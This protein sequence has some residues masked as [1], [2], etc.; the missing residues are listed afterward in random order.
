MLLAVSQ[1]GRRLTPAEIDSR[2]ALGAAGAEQNVALRCLIDLYLNA[3]WLSWREL[4][5]IRAAS[6]DRV[7]DIA[8]SI[9]RAADDAVVALADGYDEAQRA[10]LREEEARRRE[11]VDD[12]LAGRSGLGRLAEMAERFGLRIAG[13]LIVAAVRSDRDF[14]DRDA[15]TRSIESAMLERFSARDVLVSTKDGMLICVASAAVDDAFVALAEHVEAELGK[16][17]H[18]RMGVGRPHPG[19]GGVVRSYEEAR[20]TIELAAALDLVP[21]VVDTADLLV[22]QVLLR[23]RAAI[24]DLV[25]TVLGPL[26]RTRGGAEPL[27]QTLEAYFSVGGVTAAAAR[28]LYL[29]V[30]AV[31]YRLDRIRSL[32]GK[33]VND[34]TDRFTLETAVMGARLLGWPAV[35]L[36]PTD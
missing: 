36:P 20:G 14:V 24:I 28:R 34:P 32:T 33:D 10:V 2:R 23:D 9:L 6:G 7:R 16:H 15:I 1:T 30:R 8:E 21:R 3:T 5:A 25:N 13:Q 11:F 26:T 27:L 4:P 19:P 17:G 29:S 31:G 22:F 35:T 12:L 18:W